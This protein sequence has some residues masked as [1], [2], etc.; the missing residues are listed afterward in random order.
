MYIYIYTYSGFAQ[1][2]NKQGQSCCCVYCR[3]CVY[4]VWVVVVVVVDVVVVLV[5]CVVCLLL[6]LIMFHSSDKQ[7]ERK[8]V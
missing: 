7:G 1:E 2:P 5:V 8:I 6:L 3:L 4:C